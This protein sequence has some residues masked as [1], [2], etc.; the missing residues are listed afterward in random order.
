MTYWIW[1]NKYTAIKVELYANSPEIAI[2]E[3]LKNGLEL[4][5]EYVLRRTYI[6]TILHNCQSMRV[7]IG[8]TGFDLF[9]SGGTNY[10]YIV[11]DDFADFY[12]TSCDYDECG[13]QVIDTVKYLGLILLISKNFLI[14]KIKVVENT[15]KEYEP[16]LSFMKPPV[17]N[18]ISAYIGYTYLRRSPYHYFKYLLNN[19]LES[20]GKILIKNSHNIDEIACFLA[21]RLVVNK[22]NGI[23]LNFMIDNQLFKLTVYPENLTL[24]PIGSFKLKT[25]NGKK[26][27]DI[28]YYTQI[29]MNLCK[30]LG[31]R[32]METYFDRDQ[33]NLDIYYRPFFISFNP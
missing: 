18:T 11:L 6:G 20:G 1:G 13:E 26:Y 32:D 33:D 12:T 31:I 29:F 16:E 3:V 22:E 19:I 5:F 14:K 24:K 30:D 10:L 27:I 9:F 7:L 17:E 21:G 8:D 15:E 23:I 4:N 2:E 25:C 28:A